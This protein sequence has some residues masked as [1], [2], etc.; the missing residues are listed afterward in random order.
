MPRD[1]ASGYIQRDPGT[2]MSITTAFARS[3]TGGRYNSRIGR[4]L[5]LRCSFVKF[6]QDV[7]SAASCGGLRCKIYCFTLL[8]RSRPR[9]SRLALMYPLSVH[10]AHCAIPL[11]GRLL[12]SERQG[13]IEQ[14][15]LLIPR[16]AHAIVNFMR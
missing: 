15:R 2:A 12:E 5:L 8:L 13:E 4:S 7:R 3:T 1:G 14:K 10:Y 9:A 11:V 6:N 16:I